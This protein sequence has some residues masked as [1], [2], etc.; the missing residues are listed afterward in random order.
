MYTTRAEDLIRDAL[1]AA[2]RMEMSRADFDLAVERVKADSLS[3]E[4][5]QENN[6]S[7]TMI[8]R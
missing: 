7:P 8:S 1:I 5:M 3:W 4:A 2:K 6:E